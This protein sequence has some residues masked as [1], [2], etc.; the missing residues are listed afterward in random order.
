MP[1][2]LPSRV[3]QPYEDIVRLRGIAGILLSHGPGFAEP[4]GLT[5]FLA[6][7]RQRSV[8]A[9]GQAKGLSAPERFRHAVII[10]SRGP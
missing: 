5:R 3:R 9:E 7:W 4:L 2:P 8:A 6:P 10:R 1:I